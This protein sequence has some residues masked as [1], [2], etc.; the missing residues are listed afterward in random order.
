MAS[1][2]PSFL[3]VLN[4]KPRASSRLASVQF[5]KFEATMVLPLRIELR[6]SP[7]PRMGENP[8]ISAAF[9]ATVRGLISGFAGVSLPYR[10]QSRAFCFWASMPFEGRSRG[11]ERVGV[12]MG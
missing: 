11:R 8:R 7:L 1:K 10:Y 12:M 2:I 4:E 9:V 6:T 5:E 3:F